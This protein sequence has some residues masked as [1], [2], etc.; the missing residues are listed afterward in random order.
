MVCIVYGS[1]VVLLSDLYVSNGLDGWTQVLLLHT[2]KSNI[3]E[4]LKSAWRNVWQIMCIVG[5]S[6]NYVRVR[7]I[8][9]SIIITKFKQS[10]KDVCT[11]AYVQLLLGF[12]FG[13]FLIVFAIGF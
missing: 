13:F 2:H 6:K 4:T 5:N 10:D 7:R 3:R 1:V 8:A 12:A 9:T 11:L